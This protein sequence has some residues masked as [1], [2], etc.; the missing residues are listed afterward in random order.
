[1]WESTAA[2]L[3]CAEPPVLH[4]NRRGK[5][6][7]WKRLAVVG[8]VVVCAMLS[9][10]S[11]AFAAKKAKTYIKGTPSA[12]SV[13]Y[14]ANSHKIAG[15]LT[16]AKSGKRLPLSKRY[17]RVYRYA[18]GKWS[19]LKKV[20]TTSKG[21][22]SVTLASGYKYQVRYW[23]TKHRKASRSSAFTIRKPDPKNTVYAVDTYN[24]RVQVFNR[25]GKYLFQF[26]SYGSGKGQL[27]Y[28]YSIAKDT[29]GYLYV[30]DSGNSRIQKFD[31]AGKFV[32]EF[33]SYGSL[34]G[35]LNNPEGI[36]VDK[37]GKSVY[38]VD[39]YNQRV[40]KFDRDGRFI[41][42]WGQRGA[43]DGQFRNA[44]QIS[45]D[46][47]GNVYV[48]DSG[49]A[50]VQKFNSDGQ[51]LTKWGGSGSGNGQFGF[52]VYGAGWG[53]AISPANVLYVVDYGNHR[54]QSF[55]AAGKYLSQF[56][57]M[58]SGN[59]QFMTACQVSLDVSGNIYVS[60]VVNCRVQKFDG[61]GNYLS[62][63]GSAGRGNG[64]FQY[65]PQGL[66]VAALRYGR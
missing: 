55:D 18:A 10:A 17:V 29:S 52:G 56:G 65:S 35:Q 11:P 25:D 36:A 59:G 40:Q 3:A 15:T 16:Y 37:T 26:G 21:K 23:G 62:Q 42:Q 45:V 58:G 51:F 24:H 57:S 63:W 12:S 6:M 47:T 38:V 61:A 64:Q 7:R 33:G 54:V 5:H 44:S 49:N 4:M 48:V 43:G 66:A 31:S 32:R 20:K 28:P 19:V 22:F 50:R 30:T 8:L 41:S 2:R 46:T 60:D 9:L 39:M 27:R 13:I 53:I 34:E 14:K 1:M